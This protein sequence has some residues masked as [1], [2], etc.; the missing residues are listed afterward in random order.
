MAHD[1][2]GWAR[3][4]TLATS[5]LSVQR[6][7]R[8]T[9]VVHFNVSISPPATIDRPPLERTLM[10]VVVEQQDGWRIAAGELTK[11]NCPE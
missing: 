5:K 3:E 10:L 7:G 1:N 6:L 8:D 2:G 9:A 11:P 4:S